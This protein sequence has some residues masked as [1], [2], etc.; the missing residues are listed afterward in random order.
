MIHKAI[1]RTIASGDLLPPDYDWLEDDQV[2]AADRVLG[3]WWSWWQTARG[4]L[5]WEPEQAFAWDVRTGKSRPIYRSVHRDYGTL[6][7]Y[8]NTRD[9]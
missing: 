4:N 2:D 9:N 7:P 5:T 1:E 6:E 8:E 3:S